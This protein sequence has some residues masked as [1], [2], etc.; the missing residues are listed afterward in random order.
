MIKTLIEALEKAK[1]SIGGNRGGLRG[2][3]PPPKKKV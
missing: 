2:L 1:F 3:S